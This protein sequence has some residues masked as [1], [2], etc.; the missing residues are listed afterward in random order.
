M[1][2]SEVA[3]NIVARLDE[4]VRLIGPLTRVRKDP[5]KFAERTDT[6]MRAV[7]HGD[8]VEVTA[9]FTDGGKQR[10]LVTVEEVDD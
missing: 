1:T 5:R 4:S 10:F 7:A 8:E 3:A 9:E 2:A 6:T